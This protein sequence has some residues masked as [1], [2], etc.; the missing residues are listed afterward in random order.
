MAGDATELAN[1]VIG[2]SAP[3]PPHFT[4]FPYRLNPVSR[5]AHPTR[6]MDVHTAAS[7]FPISRLPVS[8]FR[9]IWPIRQMVPPDIL[10]VS[11][12]GIRVTEDIRDLGK[13]VTDAVLIGETLMR[14]KNKS[15]LLQEWKN[16]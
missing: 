7:S 15:G 11:E 5:T 2:T 16:V 6:I 10:F 1:P 12:S 14:A 9:I 3:A 4:S 13:N 8:Q